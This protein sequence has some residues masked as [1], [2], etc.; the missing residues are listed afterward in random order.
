MYISPTAVAPSSP[1]SWPLTVRLVFFPKKSLLKSTLPFSFFGTFS[2]FIVVTWNISPAPSASDSVIRGVFRYTKPLSLKNLC[3]AK[4]IAW[5]ILSTA[6]KVFVRRRI[7]ATVRR[8]SREVSFFWSGNLI[9]SHSPSTS[10]LLAWISTACP[11]PTDSTRV[12]ETLMLAPVVILASS[13]SSNL[14]VSA[15]T[16][17]LLTVDPSLRAMNLICLLPLFVLTQPLARTSRPGSALRSSFTL[18][19]AIVLI[20]VDVFQ[21]NL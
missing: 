21:K 18:V 5:R 3:M 10:M 7:C 8:Y 9:G 1:S 17:I 4:A 15:T 2:R 11:L 14:D 12:P 16:W 20:C 13:E 19:L 6:P